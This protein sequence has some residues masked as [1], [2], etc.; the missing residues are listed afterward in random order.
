MQYPSYNPRYKKAFQNVLSGPTTV[1]VDVKF[2][3]LLHSGT[4]E[5]WKRTLEQKFPSVF[6]EAK[7]NQYQGLIGRKY[8]PEDNSYSICLETGL[9]V[10]AML[11][12]D[13]YRG[14]R[15]CETIIVK[16]P[17]THTVHNTG[18]GY[19]SEIMVDVLYKNH[20]YRVL[21]NNAC[22]IK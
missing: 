2:L 17:Y 12:G 20:T 18:I 16:E 19:K 10:H 21:F 1:E 6:P 4:C 13:N 14:I 15:H 22:V 7:L 11:P 9:S 8:V 3:R 5:V